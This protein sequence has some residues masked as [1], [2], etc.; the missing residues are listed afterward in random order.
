VGR[1]GA[2]CFAMAV[3]ETAAESLE[4][5]WSR[6]HAGADAHRVRVGAAIFDPERPATLDAL[7]ER[8]ADDLLPLAHSA[9]R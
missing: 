1:V 7:M 4:T 5:A 2:D 9:S 6:I 8:A 3:F